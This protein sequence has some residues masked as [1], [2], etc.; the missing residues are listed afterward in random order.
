[1]LEG[2]NLSHLGPFRSHSGADKVPFSGRT[3][4]M[5]LEV[6]PREKCP[7]IL[8]SAPGTQVTVERFKRFMKE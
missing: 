4:A 8:S 1:M 5:R 3:S 6:R 2:F 7:F